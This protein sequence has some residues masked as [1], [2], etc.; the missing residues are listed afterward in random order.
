MGSGDLDM[1]TFEGRRII[2]F[3]TVCIWVIVSNEKKTNN[4]ITVPIKYS[5]ITWNKWEHHSVEAPYRRGSK[6]RVWQWKGWSTKNHRERQTA[7]NF[8][9]IQVCLGWRY[10]DDLMGTSSFVHHQNLRAL[11]N[12]TSP[13]TSRLWLNFSEEFSYRKRIYPTGQYLTLN[14][15]FFFL[16][17]WCHQSFGSCS[18]SESPGL[19]NWEEWSW[20]SGPRKGHK[21]STALG[22]ALESP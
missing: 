15:F 11:C 12:P 10:S 1:A 2:L 18:D 3:I 16:V 20:I 8:R 14:F 13:G 9:A 19:V 17:N 6:A 21:G 4:E 5:K 22:R 7:D